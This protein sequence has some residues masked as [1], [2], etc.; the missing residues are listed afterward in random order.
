[1]PI[2]VGLK[3]FPDK[4]GMLTGLAVAGFGFGASLWVKL[5]GAWGNLIADYGL[6]NVFLYYGVAFAAI[7]SIGSI[8][9]VNPPE[10]YCPQGW[11]PPEP[12]GNGPDSAAA[13][14]GS[15]TMLRP[16]LSSTPWGRFGAG[17]T[18]RL[19]VL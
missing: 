6:A 18:A 13:D 5:A 3:W 12:A 10:G 2:A 19:R 7:V 15:S 9:M 8:W 14:V 16:P 17:S 1:M 11:S 4:K